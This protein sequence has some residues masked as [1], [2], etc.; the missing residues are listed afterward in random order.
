VHGKGLAALTPVVI[1]ASYKGS[2]EKF[3]NISKAMGGKGAEDCADRIRILLKELNLEYTLGDLGI[4]E[5]DIPWMAENCTKV[6]AASIKNN[7]V[8]FTKEEIEELYKKAL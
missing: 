6:S 3:E 1:D 4:E 8:V 5:K 7:P 2:P